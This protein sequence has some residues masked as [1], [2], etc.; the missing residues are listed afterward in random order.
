MMPL[1]AELNNLGHNVEVIHLVNKSTILSY[2]HESN[3]NLRLG[4]HKSN[5]Q[6]I[7]NFLLNKGINY[8][9]VR[10]SVCVTDHFTRRHLFYQWYV[11]FV[12]ALKIRDSISD[13]CNFIGISDIFPKTLK[14]FCHSNTI[15]TLHEVK[16]DRILSKN[17]FPIYF[18]YLLKN[19]RK[20]K[21]IF[22]SR[23][24]KNQFFNSSQFNRK[25]PPVT[26]VI[27]FGTFNTYKTLLPVKIE[28]INNFSNDDFVILF[29]GYFYP[30]KGLKI[31]LE[32]ARNLVLYKNIKFII[33]GSG[34]PNFDSQ[35]PSNII[36]INKY[37]SEANIVYLHQISNLTICPYLDASQSGIP[38][39]SYL[40]SKPVLATS[41]GAF[42][43]YVIDGV[44]G[45][46]VPPNNSNA[47]C[48]AILEF[49]CD[50][51]TR[52]YWENS[53]RSYINAE[54]S[55]LN[56]ENIAKRYV[57]FVKK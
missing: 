40:F 4:F 14:L 42:D 35:L 27:Y 36:F 46:L 29:Y 44:T 47:L 19:T 25:L 57:E 50:F 1:A 24:V 41:V 8:Q 17:L 33:A 51:K 56:W 22:H 6:Y 30:Y 32:T 37:L 20:I 5:Q 26:E 39:T 45:K 12:L 7:D 21:I 10:T 13:V 28:S 49:Y 55:Q 11:A 9:S 38:L 48:S 3:V 23:Y 53:V 54:D 34:D 15:A 31:L 18:R 2:W 52:W 43:E 16:F